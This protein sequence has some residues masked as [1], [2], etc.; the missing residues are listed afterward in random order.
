MALSIQ[1]H[2]AA[3]LR[4]RYF[5]GCTGL[6]IYWLGAKMRVLLIVLAGIK[7]AWMGPSE[8]LPTE[9]LRCLRMARYGA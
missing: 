5:L 9:E 3:L 6:L 8:L 7:E 2:S 1:G 4:V